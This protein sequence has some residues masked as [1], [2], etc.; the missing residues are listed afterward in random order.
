MTAYPNAKV[1]FGL[2]PNVGT[3]GTFSGS[4]DNFVLGLDGTTTAFDFERVECTTGVLGGPRR[5]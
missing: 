5:R 3:G 1:A 2:G 4:I